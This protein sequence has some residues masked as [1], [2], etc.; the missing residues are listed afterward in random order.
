MPKVDYELLQR[1][2][3]KC[4]TM[5]AA[6]AWSGLPSEEWAKKL[7]YSRQ[8]INN[9]ERDQEAPLETL[10]AAG[11]LIGAPLGWMEFGF[12]LSRRVELEP[13]PEG[14]GGLDYIDRRLDRIGEKAPEDQP[15][16]GRR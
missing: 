13:A 2:P 8:Q 14:A 11:R 16:R 10:R 1:S 3:V 7:G 12:G 6:R 15:A 5:R 9:F 4:R